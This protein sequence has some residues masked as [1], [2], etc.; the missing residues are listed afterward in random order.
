M[1][2]SAKEKGAC[3]VT[4][5]LLVVVAGEEFESPARGFSVRCE[6]IFPSGNFPQVSGKRTFSRTRRSR[7]ILRREF[8]FREFAIS[9][10]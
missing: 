1:A 3:R 6:E 4:D 5:S 9:Q 8:S 10:N 7:R 2:S